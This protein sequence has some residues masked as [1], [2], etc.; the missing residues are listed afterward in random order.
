MTITIRLKTSNAAFED[1]MDEV[2]RILTEWAQ[3]LAVRGV[4]LGTKPL[5]DV[6]GNMVGSVTVTGK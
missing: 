6:N 1:R 5:R 2:T 3:G 4:I